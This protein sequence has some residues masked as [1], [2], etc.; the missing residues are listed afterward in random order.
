MLIRR[1]P[2]VSVA[3]FGDPALGPDALERL[4]DDYALVHNIPARLR[5]CPGC[6]EPSVNGAIIHLSGCQWLW[7]DS[8]KGL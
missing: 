7:P 5:K 2:W 3:A 8:R 1:L 4:A 6:Q